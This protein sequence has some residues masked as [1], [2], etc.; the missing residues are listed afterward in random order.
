MP[1]E[2]NAPVLTFQNKSEE[3]NFDIFASLNH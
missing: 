1:Q 2:E 3:L